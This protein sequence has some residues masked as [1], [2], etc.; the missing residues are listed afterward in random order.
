MDNCGENENRGFITMLVGFGALSFAFSFLGFIS[1]LPG[2]PHLFEYTLA[3][4]TEEV[5]GHFMFAFVAAVP[6][7]DPVPILL[8]CCMGVA[9]D[10]DHVFAMLGF[11]VSAQPSHSL[12][13]AVIATVYGFQILKRREGGLRSYVKETVMI[14]V[15]IM[16][17][18]SY[19]VF[20]AYNHAG[21]VFP[22]LLPFT[23][24]NFSIPHSLWLV[25]EVG[26]LALASVGFVSASCLNRNH[27][28]QTSTSS[29][30][31]DQTFAESS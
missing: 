27:R 16:A 25:F 24:T 11:P 9:I 30:W 7:L 2:G 22:L 17:H 5:G 6:L 20:G 13:F 15:A 1:P 14:P 10:T 3:T 28:R 23:F 18:I 31:S 21:R 12:L 26:A 4:F 19:D 8:T 29:R